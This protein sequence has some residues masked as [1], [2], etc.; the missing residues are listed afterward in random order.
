MDI[1]SIKENIELNGY[2]ILNP[3]FSAKEVDDM[4]ACINEIE[5]LEEKLNTT[6]QIHAIRAVLK[7]APNLKEL[8]FT[9]ELKE[10]I[11]NVFGKKYF[12]VKSIYFDKPETSNW[13]VS[14]HQ[15][16][17]IAVSEKTEHTAYN[18]WVKKLGYYNVQ[19][20]VSILES[21]F[22]IRL[23]LDE[24]TASNGALKVL[25]GSHK[26][27]ILRANEIGQSKEELCEV[28]RGGIMIM[29][30]LLMHSSMRSTNAQRRR[31][32]HIELCNVNL[33]AS[34][35]WHEYMEL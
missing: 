10:L 31:V 8:I 28:K 20:P 25:P 27:G 24:T 16:M 15:D 6:A 13:F 12:V 1:G 2:A 34:M 5:S 4:I 14:Y 32:V 23:H 7:K 33:P 29:K 30:P 9:T 11:I 35:Q 26:K 22:T 19:P 17:S 21:V 3:V 18:N